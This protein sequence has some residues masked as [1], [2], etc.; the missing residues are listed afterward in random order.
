MTFFKR[1]ESVCVGYPYSIMRPFEKLS[2]TTT[3]RLKTQDSD[4]RTEFIYTE[5]HKILI[6]IE[7]F[8]R[9]EETRK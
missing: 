8:C 6:M 2:K 9:L 5:D 1:M 3:F 4:A 7:H